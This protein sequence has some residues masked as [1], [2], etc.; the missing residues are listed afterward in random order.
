MES[1]FCVQGT[2]D[3]LTEIEKHNLYQQVYIS[4]NPEFYLGVK[5]TFWEDKMCLLPRLKIFRVASQIIF[6]KY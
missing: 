6:P 1:K 3:T 4:V 2:R 5:C